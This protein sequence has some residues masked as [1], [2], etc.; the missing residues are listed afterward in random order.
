MLA[1][2]EHAIHRADTRVAGTA[3]TVS[4]WADAPVRIAAERY[5]QGAA[6]LIIATESVNRHN[7]INEGRGFARKLAEAGVSDGV[8]RVADESVNAWQ[9]VELSLPYLRGA[10]DAGLRLVAGS[11]WHH[12]RAVYC[13]WTR[14]PG[15]VPLYAIGWEPAFAG[16]VVTRQTWPSIPDARRR[17]I[18]E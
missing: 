1:A 13:L 8:I 16:Q 3:S 17:V 18:R 15:A 4:A 5:H 12:Q 14:L 10:L 9:N 6:P 2:G 11:K 7:G